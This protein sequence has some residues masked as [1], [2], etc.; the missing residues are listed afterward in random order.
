MG[1]VAPSLPVFGGSNL[2]SVPD[3]IRDRRRS[4]LLHRSIP[5]LHSRLC[6]FSGKLYNTK[7]V[8]F[9]FS[10]NGFKVPHNV[11]GIFLVGCSIRNFAARDRCHRLHPVQL[12]QVFVQLF[13]QRFL[14]FRKLEPHPLRRAVA[15]N[16]SGVFF[17]RPQVVHRLFCVRKTGILQ[18][19][20][21]RLGKVLCVQRRPVLRVDGQ[22]LLCL[23]DDAAQKLLHRVHGLGNGACL[24]RVLVRPL[25]LYAA[26]LFGQALL[27]QPVGLPQR[28][29]LAHVC[30]P[31][32]YR[33][34]T[35][36]GLFHVDLPIPLWYSSTSGRICDYVSDVCLGSLSAASIGGRR[37]FA[38]SFSGTPTDD[39]YSETILFFV[40]LLAS[41][42]KAISR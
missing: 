29:A 15:F 12:F 40:P 41:L 39:K 1:V 22:D 9:H 17:C 3:H 33:L 18:S 2:F 37:A 26:L 23:A 7:A 16:G 21:L 34:H 19:L 6:T 10:A 24:A 4:D 27:P 14:T 35:F 25:P 42:N 36:P 38:I 30:F 31:G 20:L 28:A 8:A 13:F 11:L 32:L 5:V